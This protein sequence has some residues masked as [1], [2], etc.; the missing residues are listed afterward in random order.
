MGSA[1]PWAGVTPAPSDKKSQNGADA[2]LLTGSFSYVIQSEA[3]L[4]LSQ[5]GEVDARPRAAGEGPN[6]LIPRV[7]QNVRCNGHSRRTMFLTLTLS[8]RGRG[9]EQEA[10]EIYPDTFHRLPS[11]ISVNTAGIGI[12]SQNS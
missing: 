11:R 8:P 3:N 6:F 12:D 9:S 2:I 1:P 10:D 4:P 7:R 5:W